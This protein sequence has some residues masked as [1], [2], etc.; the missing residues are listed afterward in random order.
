MPHTLSNPAGLHN[1][2]DYGY[3]HVASVPKAD[4]VFVAGQ[5]ASD[6]TGHVV[7][8]D[9]A[10]Q[11]EQSFANIGRALAA[12]GLGF[13]DVVQLRTF[14]VDHDESKL[15]AL[16]AV[17]SRIWGDRPPTQTLL[18]VAAL[19]LPDMKFEVDAVAARH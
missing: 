2:V 11:V 7:A 14:I 16:L 3:S 4:L 13:G 12:Q 15:G 9:F 8:D 19:A 10:A 5:Y 1:P 18:G 6:E 17:I